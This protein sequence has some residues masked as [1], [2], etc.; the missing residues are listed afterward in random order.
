MKADAR[1]QIDEQARQLDVQSVSWR[2]E[3]SRLNDLQNQMTQLFQALQNLSPQC[4]AAA[5]SSAASAPSAALPPDRLAQQ[6][7]SVRD[8]LMAQA[9]PEQTQ[10]LVEHSQMGGIADVDMSRIAAIGRC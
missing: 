6:S 9:R 5:T 8:M 7:P 2:S 10:P 3:F 1:A 4:R